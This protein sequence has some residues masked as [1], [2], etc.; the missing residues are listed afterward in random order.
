VTLAVATMTVH[1]GWAEVFVIVAIV[2]FVLACLFLLLPKQ[3]PRA[4]AHAPLLVAL[5][6]VFF[7]LSFLC[8]L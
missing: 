4:F 5:G 6:L 8:T 7:A 1:T 3:W 2:A